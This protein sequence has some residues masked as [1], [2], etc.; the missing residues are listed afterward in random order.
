MDIQ[1]RIPELKLIIRKE[2]SSQ[3]S[4][5]SNRQRVGIINATLLRVS[6]NTTKAMVGLNSV[7]RPL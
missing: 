4:L 6:I 7:A 2:P 3:T 5:D 1:I